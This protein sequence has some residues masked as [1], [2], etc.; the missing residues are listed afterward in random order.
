VEVTKGR[1]EGLL[2]VKLDVFKDDRGF[3]VERYNRKKFEEAGLPIDHVQDN[4][5]RSKPGVIRGLHYQ[6]NPEQGKFV[7][8]PRGVI[9]D[10]VVDIRPNSPTFGEHESI[11]ISDN[12]ATMFW[13]PAGFAHGFCVLEDRDA[14]V[15]YHVNSPYNPAGEGGIAWDDPELGIEWPVKNPIISERDKNLP[16]F[17]DYKT[18]LPEWKP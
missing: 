12:N 8:V 2:I 9:W 4:H 15:V 16:S 10:V 7:G 17:A 5:S 3:F 1:L 6:T 14:D 11:E 18:N 13:I